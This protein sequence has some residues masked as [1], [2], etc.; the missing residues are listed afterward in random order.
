MRLVSLTLRV[1]LISWIVMGTLLGYLVRRAARGF[2]T[3]AERDTLRGEALARLLERLGATFIKF[4][5]IL[6]TRPDLLNTEYTGALAKLQDAVAEEPF[7]AISQ[8]L[9]EELGERRE[10]LASVEPKSLAAA[11]VAQVHRGVL[12]TGEVVAIK[13]QRPRA[14]AQIERDLVILAF[15]ARIL[16]RVPTVRLLSLPGAVERF[17]EALT[18]QLDFHKETENNRRFAVNFAD[19]EGID[20]PRLFEELCTAKVIVMEFVEGVKAT[21]PERVGGDRKRLAQLGGECILK[22]TFTDGFVHADLHPGNIILTEDSRVVLIDLGMVTEIPADILR[23]WVQTFVALSQQDGAAAARVFYGYAPSV[24]CKDY[25]AFEAE[26]EEYLKGIY[27]KRL[28]EVEISEVVGGMMNVL[29]KHRVQIDPTFTVVNL[30]LLVA[31]GLGK[32]LDPEIDLI[33]LA[34]PYLTRAMLT[35]PPGRPPNRPIPGEAPDVAA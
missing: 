16:D 24:G 21:E 25:A 30:A 4:G 6:S 9:D 31:E 23:P 15:G 11:S 26:V 5:Q 8:V 35:A 17:G 10:R 33:P 1:F 13:V 22:M 34:T 18:G 12:D 3:R 14:A 2:I 27:G 7:E 32:Q 19:V 20:V 28:G 29:R